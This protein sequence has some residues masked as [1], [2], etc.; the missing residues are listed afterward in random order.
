MSANRFATYAE[1]PDAGMTIQNPSAA[2]LC[3]DSADLFQTNTLLTQLTEIRNNATPYNSLI[4]KKQALAAGKISRIALTELNFNWSIPT[5]TEF[6]NI[7]S[8]TLTD[9]GFEVPVNAQV[10]IGFYNLTDLATALAADLAT[11]A[12]V[13]V[14]GTWT[15]SVDPITFFITVEYAPAPGE[16]WDNLRVNINELSTMLGFN[17]QS[18]AES[19]GNYLKVR[20]NFPTLT[21]TPYIDIVSQRLTKNQHIYDNSSSVTSPIRSL[22]ARVYLNYPGLAAR[23]DEDAIPGARPFTLN[24][25]FQYPKQIAWEPTENIDSIDLLIL[26]SKGRT[27]YSEPVTQ[28]PPVTDDTIYTGNSA[29]FQFNLLVSEN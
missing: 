8:V 13:G 21:Y 16:T 29:T 12:P 22:L 9:P 20:S 27:L 17:G 4:Y 25:E 7:F 28:G 26:D 1:R 11:A 2:L 10:D 6:N 3:V 19:F 24:K 5:I 23:L 18:W 14:A 15:V